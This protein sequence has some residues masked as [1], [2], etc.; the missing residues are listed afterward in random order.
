M[1]GPRCRRF[2]YW[3]TATLLGLCLALSGFA[4]RRQILNQDNEI[5][6]HDL[7]SLMARTPHSSDVL[8]TSLDTVFHD[9]DIC[10]GRD[11]AL[12]DSAEAADPHSLKDVASK[13]DGRHLM[14]DGRPIK[15][16]ARYLTADQAN[17]GDLIT[18]ILN[19]H[20]L[21]MQWNSRVYVVHGLVYLW[22]ATGGGAPDGSIS[23]GTVIHKLL[24]WDTRYSDLRRELV[25]DRTSEDLS[26]V[27][28]LLFLQWTPE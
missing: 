18:S 21:L 28:G 26:K 2:A 8:L 19:Q 6:V 16:S 20:A 7:P 5:Q 1:T 10:C 9:P 15:V 25:F 22:T 11:S 4:A 3:A 14:G 23:E 17:S 24:L 27:Q 12:G 13:L